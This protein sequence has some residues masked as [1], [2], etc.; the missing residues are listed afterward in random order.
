MS[1]M[2]ERSDKSQTAEHHDERAAANEKARSR[3][4]GSKQLDKVQRNEQALPGSDQGREKKDGKCG[5]HIVLCFFNSGWQIL[6]KWRAIDSVRVVGPIE[7][8][9]AHVEHRLAARQVMV[10]GFGA[11]FG[12]Q[13]IAAAFADGD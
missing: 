8:L 1:Q 9:A 3:G 12:H 11:A 5:A 2:E 4:T 6:L 10:G 7:F 13:R